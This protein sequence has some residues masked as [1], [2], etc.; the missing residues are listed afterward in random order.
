MNWSVRTVTESG[1]TSGVIPGSVLEAREAL[2]L[3]DLDRYQIG[4]LVVKT[5]AV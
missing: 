2:N 4:E 3:E 1:L 5:L